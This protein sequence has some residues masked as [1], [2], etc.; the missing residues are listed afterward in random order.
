MA[1]TRSRQRTL[2]LL[3]TAGIVGALL[4]WLPVGVSAADLRQGP[5]VTLGPGQTLNDDIYAACGTISIECNVNGSV[6]AAGGI[7]TVSGTVS[8]DVMIAGGTVNVSGKVAGSIRVAGGNLTLNAPVGQAGVGAG[9][10]VDIPSGG[11]I[12]RALA[13]AGGT[14][15]GSA[16]GRRRGNEGAGHL[17]LRGRVGCDGLGRGRR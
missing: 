15:A 2:W 11:T 6:V 9:G 10:T 3:G 4:A 7:I 12:R 1:R 16:A 13:V 17:D 8:R 5:N 14:A